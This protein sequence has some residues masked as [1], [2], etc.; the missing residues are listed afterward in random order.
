MGLLYPAIVLLLLFVLVSALYT[1]RFEKARHQR[2]PKMLF[3]VGVTFFVAGM[4]ML[5]IA[6]GW[7]WGLVGLGASWLTV[8]VVNLA[9][10]VTC[11]VKEYVDPLSNKRINEVDS[12]EEKHKAE[13]DDFW[14]S[15]SP[16]EAANLMVSFLD[17]LRRDWPRELLQLNPEGL[18]DTIS[19]NLKSGIKR[20]YMVG[21][22][23]GKGWISREHLTDFT[24]YLGDKLAHE[25]TDLKRTKSNGNAFAAGYTAVSVQGILSATRRKV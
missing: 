4:T 22:M 8:L 24:L 11:G 2:Q 20:A 7:K 18:P 25:V 13:L 19:V 15:T 5:F 3:G 23:R 10:A 12:V 1:Y 21:C 6:A 9:I 17:E 14:N 16:N